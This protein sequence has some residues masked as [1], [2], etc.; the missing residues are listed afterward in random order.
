MVDISDVIDEVSQAESSSVDHGENE[1]VGEG[2]IWGGEGIG[3]PYG[4]ICVGVGDRESDRLRLASTPLDSGSLVMLAESIT[5][6]YSAKGGMRSV[7]EREGEGEGG[8]AREWG[9]MHGDWG[10]VIGEG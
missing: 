5:G 4:E 2:S 6:V 10:T 7:G 8:S 3:D 1:R 9:R